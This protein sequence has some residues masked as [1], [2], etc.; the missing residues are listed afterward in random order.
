M[1]LKKYLQKKNEPY[2]KQI[3]ERSVALRS[4]LIGIKQYQ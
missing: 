3:E 4:P 2:K 1:S